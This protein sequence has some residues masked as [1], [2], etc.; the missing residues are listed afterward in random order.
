MESLIVIICLEECQLPRFC[1]KL[2]ESTDLLGGTV[3]KIGKNFIGI[4][5]PP[6]LQVLYFLEICMSMAWCK[7][8]LEICLGQKL[9]LG[10]ESKGVHGERTIGSR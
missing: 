7:L 6:M 3:A 4:S 5:S 1:L 2:A 8:P 9:Q 10:S